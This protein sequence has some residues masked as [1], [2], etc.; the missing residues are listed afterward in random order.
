MGI[1]MGSGRNGPSF[2]LVLRN[3]C[4][5]EKM[6]L[7]PALIPTFFHIGFA[8]GVSTVGFSRNNRG[9]RG[10]ILHPACIMNDDFDILTYLRLVRD[11]FPTMAL[12][13]GEYRCT[14]HGQLLLEDDELFEYGEVLGNGLFSPYW[15]VK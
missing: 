4:N 7:S 13:Y 5:K 10:G 14:G 15:W 9:I 6:G 2:L 8:C 12:N 1:F 3:I 11:C